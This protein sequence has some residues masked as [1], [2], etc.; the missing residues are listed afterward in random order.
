MT[1]RFLAAHALRDECEQLAKTEAWLNGSHSGGF[2]PPNLSDAPYAVAALQR[3]RAELMGKAIAVLLARE[4]E[5]A[6]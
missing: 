2:A 5:P 4:S 1:D 3:R 6:E